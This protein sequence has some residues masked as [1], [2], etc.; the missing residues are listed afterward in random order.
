[1]PFSNFLYVW[2]WYSTKGK[3]KIFSVYFFS[4]SCKSWFNLVWFIFPPRV[5]I[6]LLLRKWE[7]GAEHVSARDKRDAPDDI[8]K[9]RTYG[10][11]GLIAS[12]AVG[13]RCTRGARI[14]GRTDWK[15]FNTFISHAATGTIPMRENKT[16]SVYYG[17][18]M[19]QLRPE[20]NTLYENRMEAVVIN[21]WRI[22]SRLEMLKHNSLH[23]SN[24]GGSRRICSCHIVWRRRCVSMTDA[25]CSRGNGRRPSYQRRGTRDHDIGQLWYFKTHSV[26]KYKFKK[27]LLSTI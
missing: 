25:P 19:F 11:S 6:M 9:V 21:S 15:Y 8:C 12:A 10:R 26:L 24:P 17:V 20:T 13:S 14:Y 18:L 16:R 7:P 3:I 23:D 4:F 22:V 27:I 2:I 1:M 5:G